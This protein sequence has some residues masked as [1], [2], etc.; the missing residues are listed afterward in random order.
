MVMY[1]YKLNTIRLRDLV[2]IIFIHKCTGYSFWDGI[3]QM[4]FALENI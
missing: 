2:D 4:C 1:M 3:S